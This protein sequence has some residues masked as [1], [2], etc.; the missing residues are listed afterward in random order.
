MWG[1]LLWVFVAHAEPKSDSATEEKTIF[2]AFNPVDLRTLRR[3]L[4]WRD[5]QIDTV[6]LLVETPTRPTVVILSVRM[7]R[8]PVVGYRVTQMTTLNGAIEAVWELMLDREFVPISYTA[9]GVVCAM[10]QDAP[11][12]PC[13]LEAHLLRYYALTSFGVGVYPTY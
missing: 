7:E 8:V 10:V 6:M 12:R 3:E 9:D 2:P 5:K 4:W 13:T 1:L 11:L